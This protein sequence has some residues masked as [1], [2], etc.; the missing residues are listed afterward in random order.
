VNPASWVTNPAESME[1]LRTFF[2]DP[3]INDRNRIQLA[4]HILWPNG[5][6]ED[7]QDALHIYDEEDE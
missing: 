3:E 2:R 5:L 4:S 7:A 6:P 1:L